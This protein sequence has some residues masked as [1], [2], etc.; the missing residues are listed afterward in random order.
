MDSVFFRSVIQATD[1]T[2]TG[3]RAKIAAARPA[4]VPPCGNSRRS[5]RHN[6][7]ALSACSRTLT[8]W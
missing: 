4:P 8:R 1:S 7:T 3:C 2:L 5:T 6:T